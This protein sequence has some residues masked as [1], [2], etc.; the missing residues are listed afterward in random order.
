MLRLNF[1]KVYRGELKKP[2]VKQFLSLARKDVRC[3]S[4]NWWPL[5]LHLILS[6]LFKF[7]SFLH[8]V[9]FVK[10]YIK[11]VSCTVD[12]FLCLSH[13]RCINLNIFWSQIFNAKFFLD[14]HFPHIVNR[15]I[16][17]YFR[18][19][20]A[21]LIVCSPALRGLHEKFLV[22]H[23]LSVFDRKICVLHK[24]WLLIDPRALDNLNQGF[25]FPMSS[26]WKHFFLL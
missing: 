14:F 1:C 21:Q 9:V 17:D 7:G 16:S 22:T 6:I 23:D 12:V 20:V 18:L 5:F 26:C 11:K 3:T 19:W 4:L 24:S 2:Q 25:F 13:E 10:N 8:N 15:N